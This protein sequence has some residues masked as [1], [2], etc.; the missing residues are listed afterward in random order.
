MRHLTKIFVCV[1]MLALFGFGAASAFNAS[2]YATTSK[3]AT[4]KWVK[5]TIPENGMYEL[6]Y[7]ELIAM[8]FTNP[9]QVKVYGSGG[10]RIVEVLNGRA[11]DKRGAQQNHRHQ[12]H[13][14]IYV[15]YH[16]YNSF[17]LKMTV[18]SN[19]AGSGCGNFLD[20]CTASS[21]D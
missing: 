12:N 4:G 17:T 8:G 19:G 20:F 16:R 6:T 15:P 9:E 14:P 18:P 7:D 1:A 3:L 10:A 2:R 11:P 13:T 21:T 5:I